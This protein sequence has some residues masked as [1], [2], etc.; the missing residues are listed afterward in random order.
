VRAQLL[1]AYDNAEPVR[2]P[3]SLDGE[4]T[5]VRDAIGKEAPVYI[6]ANDQDH[7]YGL[8]LLDERSRRA[9]GERIAKVRDPFLRSMLW[10]GLWDA[11]REAE[12]AP[13]EFITLV[14][15]SL[16][17]EDDESLTQTLLSRAILAYQKYLSSHD[18]RLIGP[19]FERFTQDRMLKS[20]TLGMRVTYFRA[21]RSI[22]TTPDARTVL[23]SLLS[24]KLTIPDMELKPLD[25][26]QIIT[27]LISAGDGEELFAEEKKRDT[28]D[29]GRKYAW[30]AESARPDAA[31]K[32][33][34]FADFLDA[35]SVPEDWVVGALR[36]FNATSQSEL[37]RPF[38]KPSLEALPKLKHERKIFFV[39]GWLNAFLGGQHT[40]E[41]L[42]EVKAFLRDTKLEPDLERKVLEVMDELERTV[43]IRAKF[44]K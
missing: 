25:R 11:V 21:F 28:S 44:G 17:T 23:K 1:L 35:K 29:D 26:W 31:A 18:Q 3:V 43:R 4:R 9:V 12:M 30:I 34:Y 32:K 2:L 33:R 39:L 16:Q 13:R 8:F 37:T 19:M 15:K 6:L 7:A 40:P 10:G 36:S 22:A 41:A 20:A 5:I 38:L 24:G 27:A 42:D 14:M